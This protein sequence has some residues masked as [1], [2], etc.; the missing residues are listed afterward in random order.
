MNPLTDINMFEFET[1][2]KKRNIDTNFDIVLL[3]KVVLKG[4]CR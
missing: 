2:E 1:L 3:G 4:Q